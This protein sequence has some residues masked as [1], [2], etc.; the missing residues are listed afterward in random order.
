MK[1]NNSFYIVLLCVFAQVLAGVFI[2]GYAH[3]DTEKNIN[4]IR[5]ITPQWEDQT[6]PDGT[7][8]FFD[9]VKAVYNP[10]GIKMDY[11]FAPWKRCQA[12]VNKGSTDAML[13]V[14]KTH[15]D[16]QKQLTPKYPIYIEQTAAVIKKASRIS[17]FGM[18]TLD[19]RRA[20]WLRGYDYVNDKHMSAIQL[21]MWHEVDNYD[22]AWLQLN[23][24]RFDVYIDALIDLNQYIHTNGINR[25]LYQIQILWSENAY[26]AFSNSKRGA[27][28]ADMYDREIQ[29]L[30]KSG[31]LE[32]IYRRWN[33]P[34]LEGYWQD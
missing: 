14:W 17:W 11:N 9:I 20:V 34:F 6:N 10:L 33:Q 1:R 28:L 30:F 16:E 27:Y 23:L 25:D 32:R 3:A 12:K 13:C 24:D 5:I 21:A 7:G 29:K 19:Y 2:P 22:D 8:L 31:E 4:T 18:H 26:V 15:A